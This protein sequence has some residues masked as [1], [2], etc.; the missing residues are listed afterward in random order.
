MKAARI[1][2]YALLGDGQ[3]TALVATDGSIDWLCWPAFESPPCFA[4]LLGD[5]SNGYW[6][7]APDE[8][9]LRVTRRYV[10]ASLVLETT[11]HT[12]NGVLEL[13]DALAWAETPARLLRSARC[14]SGRVTLTSELSIRFDHGRTKPWVRTF[15]HR[16][17][18][19][20]GSHA[21]WFDAPSTPECDAGIVRNRIELS[22][23]DARGFVLTCCRSYDQPPVAADVRAALDVTLQRWARW[24]A[25]L[26]PIGERYAEPVRRSL[27]VLKGLTNRLTGGIAAAATRSLPE[28]IGGDL[29]WDYRYCWLRD[30]SFTMLA[31]AGTGLRPEAQAWRDWLLRA[32]AGDPAHTQTIYTTEGDSH[33]AEWECAWLDGYEASRPVRF[34]NAAVKQSQ[35]DIYGEIID[36]LYVSRCHGMPPDDDIWLLERDLIEHVRRIWKQPDNGLWESRGKPVHHTLSKVMAWL[37]LDRG[38]TSA[39]RFGHDAPI[40]EWQRDADA[41]RQSVLTHGFHRGVN[42]F[43]QAYGNDRLDA[44]ALLIPLRGFLPADD[45]RIV[46]TVDAIERRLMHDGLVFRFLDQQGERP[47]GAFIACS[48]WLAQVRQMQGREEEARALFERVLSLQSDLGLLSEEFDAGRKRQCGNFPQVFSHVALINAACF[49]DD[50]EHSL[51][52]L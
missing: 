13:T 42:T 49:F 26:D 31:L 7:I 46:A 44:S 4:A 21:L 14:V 38:I 10:A 20:G 50:A 34:G 52:A 9:V 43:T 23:G 30:A 28:R 32:L 35:H 51:H 12:A 8:P 19:I 6:R 18:A 48:C 11:M 36:A 39:T 3:A 2:D 22:A 41:I 17:A 37:A 33:I 40:D 15:D 16:I 25:R 47:E 24:S 29:N 1:E 5:A 45:P 27:S